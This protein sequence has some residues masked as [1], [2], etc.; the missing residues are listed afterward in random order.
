MKNL[1]DQ[2]PVELMQ[3]WQKG[4]VIA[5]IK[6]TRLPSR[7]RRRLLQEWAQAV[8]VELTGADYQKVLGARG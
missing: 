6:A 3:Q 4:A 8:G 5:W 2:I 1:A 7:F